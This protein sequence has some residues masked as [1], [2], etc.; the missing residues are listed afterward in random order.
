MMLRTKKN[1][2]STKSLYSN[3]YEAPHE[4][5]QAPLT[6]T[7]YFDVSDKE[8]N[9]LEGQILTIKI[10]P[11]DNQ[12]PIVELTALPVRI[13]EGGYLVLNETLIQV[14]DIDS[15]KEQLNL[16][17]DS[18]PNFGYLEN[19]Q[20]GWWKKNFFFFLIFLVQFCRAAH[21]DSEYVFFLFGI[22]DIKNVNILDNT[23]LYILD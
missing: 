23:K 3:R 9:I 5:G 1:K 15:A 18:Q 10:E 7:I 14:I 2:N 19:M 6:E 17:I 21:A 4:V 12:A 8:G 16:V 13:A 22:L 11:L 20:K